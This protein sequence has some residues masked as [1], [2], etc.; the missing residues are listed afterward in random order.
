[1]HVEYSAIFFYHL[2]SS[3][4][5]RRLWKEKFHTLIADNAV[6][7]PISF[8]YFTRYLNIFNNLR[9]T[10]GKT[11]KIHVSDLPKIAKKCKFIHKQKYKYTKKTTNREER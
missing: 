10:T 8:R 6:V 9:G 11:I 7:L 1:L 3:V 4:L 2:Q 5:P